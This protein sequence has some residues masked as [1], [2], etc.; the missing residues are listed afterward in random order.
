MSCRLTHTA[1]IARASAL[2]AA[3]GE[4]IAAELRRAG[5]TELQPCHGDVLMHVYA[6]PGLQLSE[7]ARLARRSRST[8]SALTDRL[9]VLG[10]V[11]KRRGAEDARQVGL[12]PTP[13]ALSH[14]QAFE[15]I[16]RRLAQRLQAGLGA[17]QCAELER[18]LTLAQAC[19]GGAE[20][21]AASAAAVT[22]TMSLTTANSGATAMTTNYTLR[23]VDLTQPRT[24]LHDLLQLTGCELSINALPPGAAVPFVHS[25]RQN[26]ELY[27]VLEGE[28]EL[29]IDG[30]V[31][32]LRAGDCFNILPGGQRA[33]RAGASA[34]LR[35]ICVQT[36]QGS[37]GQYTG[38]DADINQD[39]HAPWHQG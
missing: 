7:L 21:E 32:Q 19:L 33:L 39:V 12:Y 29:F 11:E 3:G 14:R 6:R 24:E 37:L 26:D 15:D 23:H 28:G 16:S 9:S 38:E 30:K 20:T 1:V 27:V 10:Y 4:F 8:I 36:R 2:S 25:H 18:L 35:Y 17:Q 22:A 31:E 34:P 5:L 13:L